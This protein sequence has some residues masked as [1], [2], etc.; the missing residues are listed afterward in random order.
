MFVPS[1]SLNVVLGQNSNTKTILL[2]S[3]DQ[4]DGSPK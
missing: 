2:N 4:K 1:L 3:S